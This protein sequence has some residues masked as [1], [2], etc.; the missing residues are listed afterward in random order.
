MIAYLDK[1]DRLLEKSQATDS[2]K[3]AVQQLARGDESNLIQYSPGSP[4]IKV[5]RVL[6]K[7]LEQY[8]EE[9]ISDV[10]IEGHSTCSSF[11]GTLIFGP[12]GTRIQFDWDCHWKAEQEG[13]KSWYGA[14]DQAKAARLFGYQCFR[15]FKKLT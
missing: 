1:L 15:E 14:P 6:M 3:Q 10:K 2:F 13:F 11:H 8:P 12:G 4:N 5:L 7:L 9:I